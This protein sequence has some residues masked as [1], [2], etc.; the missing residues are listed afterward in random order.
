MAKVL[1]KAVVGVWVEVAQKE[2]DIETL[3]AAVNNT[4]NKHEDWMREHLPE[5]MLDLQ[6]HV[7]YTL[8]RDDGQVINYNDAL[9][10]TAN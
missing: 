2:T 7:G 4:N 6:E 1:I 5:A 9:Q 8:I 10:A 3:I